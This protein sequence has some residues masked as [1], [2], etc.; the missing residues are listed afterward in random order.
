MRTNTHLLLYTFEQ[1]VDFVNTGTYDPELRLPP[2]KGR[3]KPGR[4]EDVPITYVG[5]VTAADVAQIGQTRHNLLACVNRVLDYQRLL[6]SQGPDDPATGEAAG[7]LY[8]FVARTINEALRSGFAW[9]LVEADGC[10][11]ERVFATTSLFVTPPWGNYYLT[12]ARL[13]AD[14]QYGIGRLLRCEHCGKVQVASYRRRQ[15]FCPFPA[16]CRSA[17]HKRAARAGK[18]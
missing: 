2:C 15:R 12:F 9:T 8:D 5:A 7:E 6:A 14:P 13:L 18:T 4:W 3:P 1:L 11:N 17:F 10:D 16:S